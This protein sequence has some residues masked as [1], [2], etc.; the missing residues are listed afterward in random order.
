MRSLLVLLAALL[1]TG[2]VV[3]KELYRTASVSAMSAPAHKEAVK[4][5]ESSVEKTVQSHYF[6]EGRAD[7][8]Y[9][10]G[11]YGEAVNDY[12]RALRTY[13][14]ASYHLKRGRAY[15]RLNYY[16]DAKIDFTSAIE[17]KGY[18]MP[19]AYLE[20]AKAYAAEGDYKSALKDLETARERGGE[21][22]EFLKTMGELN[23]KMGRYEDAKVNVQ[24]AMLNN[25]QDSDLYLLRAKVFYKLKDANQTIEDLKNSLRL[26]QGNLEAKRML[27]WVY[28]TNPLSAYR[29]GGEALR[30]AGELYSMNEE[31]QY[32][33]VLAAAYAE[34]GQFEKSVEILE[35]GIRLTADLVQKEDFRFDIKNYKK[36]KK[37]RM[38]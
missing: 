22:V 37:V 31:V 6:Y 28:A 16:N 12:T 15:M 3:N 17:M 18:A 23:Y 8:H 14:N 1:I 11:Y 19:V 20:R 25:R 10:F 21:S 26:E 35:E 27:A 29:N 33:E 7:I 13:G 9:H 32:I 30:L 2:C 34:L 36:G 38:W 24:R 4:Q 5:Y